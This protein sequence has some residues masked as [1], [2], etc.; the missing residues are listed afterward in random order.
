MSNTNEN[1][2]VAKTNINWYPGHIAKTRREI[3]ENINLVDLVFELVDARMPISSRIVDLDDL[4][5]DKPKV[6]I[7][8]K[9]DLCDKNETNKFID[10]YKD[11]G[12]IVIPLDLSGNTNMKIVFDQVS[13]ITKELNEKRL[14]K[15]LKVRTPRAMVVGVPNVGKSTFINRITNR[16]STVTGDKPGITKAISWIRINNNLELMDTPGILWPKLENEEHAHN[17][18]LLSSIKEEIMDLEDLS[19]YGLEVINKYYPNYLEERY[20]SKYE[21]FVE[22]LDII[23]KKRGCLLKGGFVDYDKVYSIILNDIRSG[24]LGNITI[25]RLN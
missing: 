12:Y 22:Y 25:D 24:S 3:K 5:K 6:L 23:G 13:I 18:A 4:I 2:S 8:T 16:K 20:G 7:M 10:Y 21:D 1:Q 9:Y 14:S 11:K 19:K 17:L 15:G